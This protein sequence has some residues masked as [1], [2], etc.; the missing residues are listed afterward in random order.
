ML[1]FTEEATIRQGIIGYTERIDDLLNE[2]DRD[3]V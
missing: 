2:L 1:D 3:S